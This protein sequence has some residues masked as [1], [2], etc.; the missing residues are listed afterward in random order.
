VTA[1]A[2]RKIF[3]VVII[4]AVS[5]VLAGAPCRHASAQTYPQWRDGLP[6]DKVT[7]A[8]YRRVMSRW[9]KWANQFWT[10]SKAL[11]SID[12][13][14]DFTGTYALILSCLTADPG[15][16]P[17]ATGI[18]KAEA[19]S[20]LNSCLASIQNGQTAS[21]AHAQAPG[22]RAAAILLLNSAPDYGEF[23]RQQIKD[24]RFD[25]V[26]HTDGWVEVSTDQST[27]DDSWPVAAGTVFPAFF[28]NDGE[29]QSGL[30]RAHEAWMELF[31]T[32]D[33]RDNNTVVEGACVKDWVDG[34][35]VNAD[36]TVNNHD[37]WHIGY[38]YDSLRLIGI[39]WAS[40]DKSGHRIPDTFYYNAPK[41]YEK[42][43]PLHLWDGRV[44]M[45][46]AKDWPQ[47]EYGETK[48]LHWFAY[49]KARYAD[50]V[51]ARME[52][53]ILRWMEWKQQLHNGNLSGF[54]Q[55]SNPPANLVVD[56]AFN[57]AVAYFLNVLYP[58]EVPAATDAELNADCNGKVH[59]QYAQAYSYRTD[60]RFA[61]WSR[62]KSRWQIVP[63]Q[64]GDHMIEYSFN[65][66]APR[67]GATSDYED[68]NLQE[69][70][71]GFAVTARRGTTGAINYV[72][73]VPLPDHKSVLSIITTV[74]GSEISG[75]ASGMEWNTIN[76]IYNGNSRTIH[77]A[78][79]SFSVSGTSSPVNTINSPWM[80]VDDAIG[81]VTV[82]SRQT[83]NLFNYRLSAHSNEGY[84]GQN[85][86]Y[87]RFGW[88][89]SASPVDHALL[90]ICDATAAQT[91]EM[92][93]G[94]NAQKL[95]TSDVRVRG[96]W[97]K[98]QDGAHYVVVSNFNSSAKS[99]SITLPAQADQTQMITGGPATINGNN[100]SA[101][102]PAQ[103]TSIVRVGEA[104]GGPP[105]P[106]RRQIQKFPLE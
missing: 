42:I 103:T 61:S 3:S 78:N 92:A 104:T 9:A 82:Y 89:T 31:A 94:A 90:V 65:S 35:N 18:S 106:S 23:L 59:A 63:R 29:Y 47:Y 95:D 83:S 4:I 69:F 6:K 39:V 26:V 67:L 22:Y 75:S 53:N 66:P 99:V 5:A 55:F 76:W 101:T 46:A 97:V 15:Y 25:A 19:L 38:T 30:N 80:N 14:F 1:R 12:R 88:S 72:A 79:N 44:A 85:T 71:G 40:Y 93:D 34:I 98:G 81:Y 62:T 84:D 11:L 86:S 73:F 60:H 64:G 54:V 43:M 45:P 33:M 68:Y 51:A 57:V 105:P 70:D 20:R 24:A 58:N 21:Y 74:Y 96:V 36:Y 49:L 8:D 102:I 50:R 77:T 41:V 91:R 16:D 7:L 28:P 10:G 87:I 52:L 100:Y 27:E 2:I 32:L 13:N 37:V 17:A 48:A 56:E